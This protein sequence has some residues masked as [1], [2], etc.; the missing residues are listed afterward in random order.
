[1]ARTRATAL[2]KKDNCILMMHRYNN[3]E[4]YW[5]LPGGGLEEGETIENATLRELKEETS[6]NATIEEKI[7]DFVDDKGDRH[8]LFLCNYLSGEVKLDDNS[9][10]ANNY[11]PNQTYIP[12]WVDIKRVKDLV[13]Y[14]I[15]QKEYLCKIK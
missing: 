13:M 2:V 3:S 5:V 15:K 10:E 7:M 8:V 9:E 14:P 6:I 4:E 11:D 12:Q 1:M